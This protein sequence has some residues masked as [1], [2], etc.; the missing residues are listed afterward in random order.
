MSWSSAAIPLM[1]QMPFFKSGVCE[2]RLL[3]TDAG[4]R[5]PMSAPEEGD[6]TFRYVSSAGKAKKVW[7]VKGSSEGDTWQFY[8]WAVEWDLANNSQVS[9]RRQERWERVLTLAG[10]TAPFDKVFS[11]SALSVRRKRAREESDHMQDTSLPLF[12][13]AVRTD[14]LLF[15][16]LHSAASQQAKPAQCKDQLLAFMQGEFLKDTNMG[17]IQGEV[18]IGSSSCQAACQ[19]ADSQINLQVL[20]ALA[21]A[22]HRPM[23]RFLAKLEKHLGQR[24]PSS[25]A[26]W[27]VLLVALDLGWGK[28]LCDSLAAIITEALCQGWAILSSDPIYSRA[29]PRQVKK[30][31]ARYDPELKKAVATIVR[32]GP[33]CVELADRMAGAYKGITLLRVRKA[34]SSSRLEQEQLGLYITAMKR[35]SQRVPLCVAGAIDG[36]RV[37]GKKMLSGPLMFIHQGLSCWPLPQIMRDFRPSLDGGMDQE[38]I[39]NCLLGFRLFMAPLSATAADA[40]EADTPNGT[41]SLGKFRKEPPRAAALDL[42]RALDNWLRSAGLALS[43]FTYQPQ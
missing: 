16:L 33:G 25:S 24:P 38:A 21:A 22:G 10:W 43:N 2:G 13:Q 18:D 42:G 17:Q 1:L 28:I 29:F 12:E 15:L 39:D 7:R 3:K 26:V 32:G 27:D 19:L 23:S 30:A 11:P 6:V 14:A 41:T 37:G 8:W 34:P 40:D 9:S 5:F 35:L 4:A 20:H 36:A 31:N